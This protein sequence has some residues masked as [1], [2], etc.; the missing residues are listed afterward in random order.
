MARLLDFVISRT[1]DYTRRDLSSDFFNSLRFTRGV[2]RIAQHVVG[3]T[4]LVLSDAVQ[5]VTNV[6]ADKLLN[7]REFAAAWLRLKKPKDSSM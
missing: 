2:F 7:G 4:A 6:D 3:E 5:S 1:C